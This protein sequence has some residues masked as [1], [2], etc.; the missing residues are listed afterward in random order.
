[1]WVRE[2]RTH[3]GSSR[4]RASSAGTS[5]RCRV[6]SSTSPTQGS[7]IGRQAPALPHRYPAVLDRRAGRRASPARRGRHAGRAGGR[8]AGGARRG[9]RAQWRHLHDHQHC[10]AGDRTARRRLGGT[11]R[12]ALVHR[13]RPRAP[14]RP[15][16]RR[17]RPAPRAHR[18]RVRRR[19]G[20]WTRSSSG[21]VSISSGGSRSRATR[22]IGAWSPSA[23]PCGTRRVASW[24]RC[25][26]VGPTPAS[27]RCWRRRAP[28]SSARD[29]TCRWRSEDCAGARAP[30][31][32]RQ[33]AL[34]EEDVMTRPDTPVHHRRGSPAGTRS[35]G[36]PAAAA[37]TRG[38]GG[39]DG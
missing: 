1:V 31:D 38:S 39:L 5:P 30:I 25:R 10:R 22:W 2:P 8:A 35:R 34:E 18:S 6:R 12:P 21:S 15:G 23:C 33:P 20:R 24:R 11:Y 32:E 4:S 28:S 13:G 3:P 9:V 37:T 16:H 19:R 29:R 36:C 27:T 14:V 26:R 17:R 7:S